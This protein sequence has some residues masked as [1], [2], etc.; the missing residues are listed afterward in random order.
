MINRIRIWFWDLIFWLKCRAG[1]K[2]FGPITVVGVVTNVEFAEDGDACFDLS[3]DDD[4]TWLWITTSGTRVLHKCLDLHCEVTPHD[5]ERLGPIVKQLRYG[6]RVRVRGTWAWDGCHH[7]RGAPFDALM[8]L[9]RAAPTLDGWLEIH[10][11]TEL[12]IL[13]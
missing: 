11:V 8:V 6:T 5:G 3:I 12:E 2:L 13:T 7:G 10:P 4:K 9:L 1:F